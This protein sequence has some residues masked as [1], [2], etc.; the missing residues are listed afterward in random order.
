[1]MAMPAMAA[2]LQQ[3]WSVCLF[4]DHVRMEIAVGEMARDGVVESVGAEAGLVHRQQRL[5]SM[6]RHDHVRRRFFDPG[7]D[8]QLGAT[9][10][11]VDRGRNGLAYREQLI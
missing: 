11:L 5:E 2:A 10:A 1:M 8:G 3:T 9:D 4:G 7:I 6:E